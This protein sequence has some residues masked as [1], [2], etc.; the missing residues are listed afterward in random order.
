[1]NLTFFIIISSFFILSVKARV[2]DESGPEFLRDMEKRFDP[3]DVATNRGEPIDLRSV[4]ETHKIRQELDKL[5]REHAK[6]RSSDRHEEADNIQEKIQEQMA[7]M[8]NVH[9]SSR[10]MP[11]EVNDI[12]EASSFN[13][14]G[15]GFQGHKGHEEIMELQKRYGDLRR[16]GK[17]E[18]AEL[19]HTTI[20]EK[21][22][23]MHSS[24]NKRPDPDDM[25]YR[26]DHMNRRKFGRGI[27]NS[28]ATIIDNDGGDVPRSR[29]R[30][31]SA[32]F[33]DDPSAADPSDIHGMHHHREEAAKRRKEIEKEIQDRHS[34]MTKHR[35][36]ELMRR[37]ET[38]GFSVEDTVVLKKQVEE[39]QELENQL[40]NKRFEERKEFETLH[41]KGAD[42]DVVMASIRSHRE[43][44]KES[45]KQLR[46]DVR[47]KRRDIESRIRD[48]IY[49]SEF[50]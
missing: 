19:V 31:R 26:H 10:H 27:D 20:R 21:L 8:H 48:K 9:S 28:E 34:E 49:N 15:P 43:K 5:H 44:A 12:N 22:R 37:V 1:M 39:Y 29:A 18:D 11:S 16:E 23:T 14:G 32:A 41:E 50:R 17:H 30:A 3:K 47:N 45:E 40:L 7:A 2:D 35:V 36:D 6:L 38:A 4:D 24:G 25:D 42:H 13:G 33:N 46:D